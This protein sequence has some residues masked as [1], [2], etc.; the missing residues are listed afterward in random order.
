[1]RDT[2]WTE[3]IHIFLEEE[4]HN[5]TLQEEAMKLEHH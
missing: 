2:T 3:E 5:V 4:L 1:V